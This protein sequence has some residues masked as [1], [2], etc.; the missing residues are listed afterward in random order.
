MGRLQRVPNPG[1]ELWCESCELVAG[2][3]ANQAVALSR[4]GLEVELCSFIGTDLAG[5]MTADLLEEAGVSRAQLAEIPRQSVTASI[6]VGLDRAMV[7]CGTDSAPPLAGP[8]PDL[9]MADVRALEANRPTVRRWRAEG[10]LVVGDVGWDSAGTWSPDDLSALDITDVFVPNV[11]EARNY[12][13]FADAGAAGGALAERCPLVVVT[14]G[15][16]GALVCQDQVTAVPSA[17]SDFR[18][19]TGAGDVFSAALAWARL[20]K[21]PASDAAMIAC[22]A[23]AMST[24]HPGSSGAPTESQLRERARALGVAL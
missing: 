8:A 13:G 22:V 10:T 7:T 2:G 1:E 21:K 23:G 14:L 11:E 12:T 24:E 9:L 4:L 17:P 15:A 16:D 19:A 5:K 18:D 6:G 3:A 20:H